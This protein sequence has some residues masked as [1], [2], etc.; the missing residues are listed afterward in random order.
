M[1]TS[2]ADIGIDAWPRCATC[3]LRKG[4]SMPVEGYSVQVEKKSRVSVKHL[5]RVT[6]E[7][8]HGKQMDSRHVRTQ[9]ADIEVPYF[10][11]KAQEFKAVRLL[12]FFVP[13]EDRPENRMLL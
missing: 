3:T 10:W 13:G 4:F 8:S 2:P 5:L 12:Q 1:P 7:C 6:A 11:G 9:T